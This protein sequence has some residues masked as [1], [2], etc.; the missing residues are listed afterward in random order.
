MKHTWT[1]R[2]F[3]DPY[4][5][6]EPEPEV[7]LSPEPEVELTPEPEVELTPE[8][9]VEPTSEPNPEF[10]SSEEPEGEWDNPFEEP[11]PDWDEVHDRIGSWW[12]AHV[13]GAGA[14][15]FFITLFACTSLV[16]ICRIKGIKLKQTGYFLALMV[17]MIVFSLERGI[18]MFIDAYNVRRSLPPVVGY[19]FMTIGLPCLTSAFALIFHAYIKVTRF[20]VAGTRI[21]SIKAI[22][23]IIIL[24]FSV[25]IAL[26]LLAGF[27]MEASH[28]LIGCQTIFIVWGYFLC[29]LFFYLFKRIYQGM[30][31]NRKRLQRMSEMGS[32]TLSVNLPVAESP[33]AINEENHGFYNA[34]DIGASPP[35]YST[36]PDHKEKISSTSDIYI[37]SMSRSH[38]IPPPKLGTGGKLVLSAAILLFILASVYLYGVFGVYIKFIKT[39][40]SIDPWPWWAYE[41]ALRIVE[42]ALGFTICFAG[43]QPLMNK[44]RTKRSKKKDPYT[45]PQIKYSSTDS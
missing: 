34:V 5:E 29:I 45:I 24:H 36:S 7:E 6:E 39:G 21:F 30:I 19:L 25:S 4:P 17:L 41:L 3:E 43:V 42:I 11:V 20:R 2:N 31:I 26:D 16:F 10:A 38:S 15:Y 12:Y 27:T 13:Y 18:F 9:E 14:M 33:V 1:F 8:P 44:I 22:V 40:E 28:L 37:N 23:I 35:G 32:I